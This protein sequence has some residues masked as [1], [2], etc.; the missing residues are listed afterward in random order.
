LFVSD[1]GKTFTPAPEGPQLARCRDVI[2]NGTQV[3]EWQGKKSNK[4]KVT[5]RWELVT[6]LQ[7]EGEFEGQ[8]YVVS[9]TYT[10][11]LAD[12]ANLRADLEAWRGKKFTPEE[13][14]N[15]DMRSLRDKAC[16][17]QVVHAVKDGKTYANVGSLMA[18]PAGMTVPP[19][20]GKSIVLSL[21][22]EY[23]V[24]AAFDALSDKFKERIAASPE[25]KELMKGEY[26]V[27]DGT[28]DEPA[29]IPF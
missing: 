12:K 11:S 4:R 14:A 15:F 20:V 24:Q 16:M 22:S 1:S 17:M 21:D 13:L 9:K 2:D 10:A 6:S 29:D 8:P 23:F 3:T 25:Y 5:I 28:P 7:A 26:F 19:L 27:T 18:V